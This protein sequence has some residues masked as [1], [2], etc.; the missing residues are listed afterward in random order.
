MLLGAKA[1]FGFPDYFKS[2]LMETPEIA[3]WI[4]AAAQL[5]RLLQI[6]I[7]GNEIIK[8]ACISTVAFPDYFKSEL[9]ET[10]WRAGRPR[11]YITLLYRL[12]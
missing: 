2:E 4:K 6:G 8:R 11:P 10:E 5:S 7:N 3:S 1:V 9:L 12:G